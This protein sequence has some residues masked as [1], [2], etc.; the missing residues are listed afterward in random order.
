M[1]TGTISVKDKVVVI[2][3]ATG[4][5]GSEYVDVLAREGARTVITALDREKCQ[6]LAGKM[7]EKYGADCLGIQ[8][9]VTDQSTIRA[10]LEKALQKYGRVDAL[11]NNAAI[12]NPSGD[13]DEF[14]YTP[15]EKLSL[16]DWN[17]TLKV[18]LTGPFLCS[19]VFGEQMANQGGGAIINIASTYGMVAPDQKLYRHFSR[20]S[21]KRFIK[22]ATYSVSKGG[23]IM[24]TRY[25]AAYW[26]DKNV[27]V[28][29]LSPGGVYDGHAAE[30]V[31]DYSQRTPLGRMADKTDYNGAILF[32]VSNSSSY[33]T[34]STL[35]VDG[36]WTIW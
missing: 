4:L 30:F 28:N 18:N 8:M 19:Q 21:A 33:M 34:G 31:K 29:A 17:R 7:S 23:I 9:D 32:L 13:N 12:N 24:L 20:G 22:P 26:G 15:F 6:V 25:L 35:T 1:N 36:G 11:I 14:F 2:T 27:R 5:L 3:G 16:E 10:V